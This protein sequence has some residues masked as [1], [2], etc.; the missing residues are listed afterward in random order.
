ML[1]TGNAQVPI[2]EGRDFD[3]TDEGSEDAKCGR[4]NARFVEMRGRER[5]DI[6]KEGKL[7]VRGRTDLCRERGEVG[8]EEL[9]RQLWPG[10][11]S[12]PTLRK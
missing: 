3:C 7:V 2:V 12:D 8:N 1:A 4:E 5:E 11:A 9:G 6:V 10:K